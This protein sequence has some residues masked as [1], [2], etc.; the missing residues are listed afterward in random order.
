[1]N[2]ILGLVDCLEASI[3]DSR[4][5]PFTDKLIIEEKVI[6]QLI[7]KL[8][9]AAKDKNLIRNTVDIDQDSNISNQTKPNTSDFVQ[10]DAETLQ[11]K[12]EAENYAQDVLSHLQL[13]VTKLQQKLMH[14]EKT[15][16]MGR[17]RLS[18][19]QK[20]GKSRDE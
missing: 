11:L 4:K 3:L 16:E 13:T 2:D 18:H 12:K 14:L 10:V 7:D 6:L 20:E 15:L 1:M 19:L 8:R 9:M 5:L 17:Q